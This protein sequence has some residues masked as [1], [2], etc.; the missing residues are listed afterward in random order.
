MQYIS[1]KDK[2]SYPYDANLNRILQNGLMFHNSILPEIFMIWNKTKSQHYVFSYHRDSVAEK[3]I[4]KIITLQESCYENICEVLKVKMDTTIH[5]FLCESPEE[6]GELYGDNE[7]VNGI[8][9]MPDKIYAV[10][11][12]NIKCIGFHEDVHL[13]SYNTLA[14][15]KQ[16]L[17]REGLAMFFDKVWW[18][19]PNEAWVQVYIDTGI[20]PGLSILADQK[21]FH[22]Y[23]DTITYPI[24]GVFANYLIALYG[25]EKFKKF[26]KAVSNNFHEFFLKTFGVSARQFESKMIKHLKNIKYDK[27][28]YDAVY[29]YLTELKILK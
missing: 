15:P 20:Y 5:Y 3:D 6:V 29:S 13:I 19:I 26:Y 7:P 11:S 10:Y 23:S 1:H 25:I 14:R 9:K 12:E 8:V 17:I 24:S 18:G 16:T 27:S 28:I 21:G 4:T 2:D 22:R